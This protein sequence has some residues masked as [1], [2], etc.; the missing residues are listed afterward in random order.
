MKAFISVAII[1]IML[2]FVQAFDFPKEED[3]DI[4]ISNPLD[5]S[6][7][8]SDSGS[9][10]DIPS[11]D[12]AAGALGISEPSKPS[13]GSLFGSSGHSVAWHLTKNITLFNY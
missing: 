12:D 5:D 13:M 4:P 7:S 6:G 3:I 10:S 9:D 2:H 8:G 11:T 1:M